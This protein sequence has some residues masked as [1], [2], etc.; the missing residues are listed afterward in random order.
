MIKEATMYLT[1]IEVLRR[2]RRGRG[3]D[4]LPLALSLV[5]SGVGVATNLPQLGGREGGREGGRG[6]GVV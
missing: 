6:G 4:V 5:D 1:G 2:D 3:R